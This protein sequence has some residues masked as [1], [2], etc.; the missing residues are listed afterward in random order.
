MRNS[1][2]LSATVGAVLLGSIIVTNKAKAQTSFPWDYGTHK[3][4]SWS[5]PKDDVAPVYYTS[6][7]NN[8]YIWN[9][10]FT[11]KLHNIKNHPYRTWYVQKSFKRNGKVY[12]KVYGNKL[13]GYVW[14]GYVT[15]AMVKPISSFKSN[16]SYVNYLKTSASQKL[17]RALLKYFPNAEV[18]VDLSRRSAGQYTKNNIMKVDN[19][20]HAI[21]LTKLSIKT[22]YPWGTTDTYVSDILQDPILTSNA[23]KA[24]QV[25][26]IM[27]KNGYNQKKIASLIDQGY[28]L[29][30]YMNDGAGV[31]ARKAGYPWTINTYSNAQ[32]DYGLYLAK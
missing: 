23:N 27:V 9:E 16:S 30:I 26:N 22:K 29:G 8:G 1:L 11:K 13:S 10:S 28:K 12:Y 7:K 5:A 14:R 32:N 4:Y 24:K 19:Y 15:P 6:T 31:S 2:L 17:S 25:N 20:E 18:S 3:N 21:N